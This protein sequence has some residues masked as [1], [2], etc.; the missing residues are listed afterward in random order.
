MNFTE[1]EF[2]KQFGDAEWKVTTVDGKI[3]KSPKWLLRYENVLYKEIKPNVDI[4]NTLQV[5]RSKS[6]TV[7]TT[8]FKTA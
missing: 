2:Y 1:T 5:V 6:K 4:K 7:I 8:K 3:Y